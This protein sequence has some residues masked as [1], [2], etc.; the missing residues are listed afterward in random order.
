MGL[1]KKSLSSIT[2]GDVIHYDA[3]CTAVIEAEAILNRRPLTQLSTDSRD[4]E[5]LTPNH[6]L[7]P[8]TSH[9]EEQ[10]QV[11][12]AETADAGS[13]RT[14]WKRAQSRVNSFWRTFRRDYLSLLHS[15]SKW[16]KTRENLKKDD[17]VIIVDDTAD[18]HDWRLGRIVST[19]QSDGHVRQVAVKR[20][21]GRIVHRDRTKL[22]KLELD[23]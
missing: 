2:S 14:S 18:R 12:M 22:V 7:C 10:P 9:L 16:R 3:F 1:F 8:A 4:T 20:G 19:I 23:E 15:R 5:A 21:D 13:I 11:E 6:L 17:L